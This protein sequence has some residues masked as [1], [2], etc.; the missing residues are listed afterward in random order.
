VP[1]ADDEFFALIHSHLLKLE[2]AEERARIQRIGSETLQA[3]ERLAHVRRAVSVFGSAQPELA[4]RWGQP[5]RETAALLANAGFTVI[6]GGGPGLMAAA[7]EGA[8]RAGGASVGLTIDLPA[9]E[10]ANPYLTL[11]VRFR[12]FFLRKLM[13]V[14]Y[15]CGFVCFP[16]GFGTLDELFEALN[17]VRTHKLGPFP[18]VLFGSEYWLG[19]AEWL[20]RT[21]QGSGGLREEDLH[22]FEIVDDPAAVVERM[23]GAHA[24]LC[25]QLESAPLDGEQGP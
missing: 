2:P 15:A 23:R 19:L 24:V 12:Y 16:G 3:L 7:N 6:T 14:K 5:A 21:V 9:Q 20:H 13:F 11:E 1:N 17:L 22:T 8:T 18:V 25:G 10:T 4:R